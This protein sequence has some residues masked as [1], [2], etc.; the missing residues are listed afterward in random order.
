MNAQPQVID[1]AALFLPLLVGAATTV[2]TIFIHG[3]SGRAMVLLIFRALRRGVAG[4]SFRT[5][6]LVI[7]LA[8]LI[9][10]TA[11]LVEVM[12]WAAVLMLCGE[13]RN[14]GLACYHSATNYSTLGYGDIVMSARWRLM[15]PLE[16]LDGILLVG[17][18]TASLFA[19]IVRVT[20]SSHPD[21]WQEIDR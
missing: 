9:M 20:R 1:S 10:L 21:V 19:V 6:V 8:A 2:L 15:G 13:F 5:D 14:F 4:V 12:L 7:A 11:H 17:I 3:A 18:S 16:A